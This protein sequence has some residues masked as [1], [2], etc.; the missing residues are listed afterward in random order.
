[1]NV[2]R[3]GTYRVQLRPEFGFTQARALTEYWQ[4]LGVSHIYCSPYLQATRGSSHGYDVVD[5][6]KVNEELGGEAGR[7]AFCEALARCNLRQLIDIVPNHM[8]I[9]GGHNAWWWDVLEN[10]P[11]SRFSQ[12]FDVEWRSSEFERVLLPILGD[13]YG[14][15]LEAGN[16]KLQRKHGSMVIGYFEHEG[17]VAPRALGQF[18]RPVAERLSHPELG[19][20]ADALAELPSPNATDGLSRRRRHRDK[21]VL[22][23]VLAGLCEQPPV[24]EA[25]DAQ[26]AWANS[27]ADAMH[28]I[29]EGQN[30]RLA[31]WRIGNH[32]LDY[33]RFFDI[34]SLVGLRVEEQEVFEA[35]H[36]LVAGWLA[37]GTV[38]GL[39]IDHIDGL[40]D[41]LGYLNRLTQASPS[42][43]LLVEKILEEGEELPRWPVSGTTGYEFLNLAQR[44][45]THPEGE[46]PLDALCA[47]LLGRP[48]DYPGT[49]ERAK[50]LVLREALGSDL[51]RLVS[52][53]SDIVANH[54]RV[55]DYSRHQLEQLLV[56]LCVE[57]PVYRTYVH[58]SRPVVSTDGRI[59][60]E[61][62]QRIRVKNPR[63]D[64]RLIDFVERLLLLELRGEKEVEFVLR[65]Q[66]LT[67]PVM[68]KGVEDTT[69]YRYVRLV[70][71]NEVGGD[72]SVFHTTVSEFHEKMEQRQLRHP[73]ALNAT[74]THDT[75]R[76]EDVRAR[77]LALSEVP[78]RWSASLQ[79]F[80][81]AVRA[82]LEAE[83]QAEID[84]AT[85]YLIWQNL[86]GAWPID[87]RR[88]IEYARKASREAKLYTS[89]HAP[90]EAYE[91]A[92]QAYI[93]QIFEDRDL[94]ARLEQLVEA[95]AP[96]FEANS[97]SQTLLK[98]TCPGVPDIY[99]GTELWD[100]SLV[101]PDNRRPVDYGLRQRL[102]EGLEGLSPM[103]VWERRAS[104][105]A[106]LYVLRRALSVRA[107]LP[108]CFGERGA[109]RPLAASGG[110][111]GR[112][113]AFRRGEAVISVTTLWWLVHGDDFEGTTFA[114]PPGTWLN[115]FTQTPW[116]GEVSLSSLLGPFPCALLTRTGA[117]GAAL[118]PGGE[119]EA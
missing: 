42:A 60:R 27:S 104:G 107:S 112:V 68:A 36:A 92:L 47:E 79:G 55:R 115:C 108:D 51:N 28:E 62:C 80:R 76:S 29:L 40:Y 109:Y 78:E 14:V 89:W 63:F 74:S 70:A 12:H 105:A 38:D 8:A 50:R 72:P 98:V 119:A 95:L 7:T 16:I 67:G 88:L 48:Q 84:A 83:V 25:I 94:L 77:L 24:A 106:K 96:G 17:P 86:V 97:L 65:L 37:D 93:A 73:E 1:M 90:N 85:E 5:P 102:L 53:L 64:A 116:E 99:Q 114:L 118:R 11:S 111:A 110:R 103:E 2:S 54:R 56:E 22:R 59:V 33:R 43:W 75:K 41:P 30:Y 57:F 13:Q 9:R 66:Q 81:H 18:L 15:E 21:E 82:G 26:I 58:P 91:G 34:D 45:L 69:F 31:F 39:R 19:F 32:E 23:T 10:G 113:L 6:G 44:V 61:T 3:R 46:A 4:K 35:T 71:L 87:A 49:V 52:R 101:D 100:F 117:E 20:V